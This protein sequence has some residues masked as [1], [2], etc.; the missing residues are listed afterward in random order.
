MLGRRIL[1]LFCAVIISSCREEKNPP[2][3]FEPELLHSPALPMTWQRVRSLICKPVVMDF[4]TPK[5]CEPR[6]PMAFQVWHPNTGKYD[7]CDDDGCSTFDGEVT[8]S[9]SYANVTFSG[10]SL[11]FKV[12]SS[13]KFIEIATLG[14]STL[15]YRGQ[16]VAQ[17]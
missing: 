2:V 8:Y 10:R 15:V 5:S 11:L 3:G 13:N 1:F 9:G 17:K 6:K 4:C 14:N 7:R 16:C 12:S